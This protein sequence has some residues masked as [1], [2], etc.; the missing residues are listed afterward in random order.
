MKA[1]LLAAGVGSRLRPITDITPKCMLDI[2][3]RPLLDT[4]FDALDRV[5]VDEVLVNL[6]HLPDVVRSHLAT[7]EGT[8]ALRIV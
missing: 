3:G 7:H 5:G 1:F 4:W 6:H 2:G 8:P